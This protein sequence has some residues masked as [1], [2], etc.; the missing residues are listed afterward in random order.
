MLKVAPDYRSI[1]YLTA[2]RSGL[3]HGEL[4]KLKWADVVFD[5]ETPHIFARAATTKN[6][7]DSRIP[8]TKELEREDWVAVG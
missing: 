4:T 5:S 8:M 2:A 7:L 6:R 3:R 1:A